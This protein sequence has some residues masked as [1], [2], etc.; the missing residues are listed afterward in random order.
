MTFWRRINPISCSNLII[1]VKELQSELRKEEKNLAERREIVIQ[2][3]R[4]LVE[5]AEKL[6]IQNRI[7]KMKKVINE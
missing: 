2:T 5:V 4:S 1:N 7:Y 6:F 3:I